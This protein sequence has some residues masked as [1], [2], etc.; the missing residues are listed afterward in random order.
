M[1]NRRVS[2]SISARV[3]EHLLERGLTL[4][5]IARLIGT[6]KSFLSRVKN[7]ERSFTIDHLERLE[8]S[9][10]EPL[11][12]LLI[13]ATDVESVPDELRDIYRATKRLLAKSARMR[14]GLRLHAAGAS[15]R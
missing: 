1:A 12:H 15:R 9:L 14:A 10:A 7:R 2:S 3:V 4:E 8:L 13:Q 6:T 5:G 11:P